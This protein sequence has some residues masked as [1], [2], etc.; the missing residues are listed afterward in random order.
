M[1]VP[2]SGPQGPPWPLGS[3]E[4]I[5]TPGALTSGFSCSETG[6]GPAEEKLAITSEVVTAA[7]VIAEGAF[8]GELTD[9]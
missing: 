6:V 8:P 3:E 1:L 9:P 5:P 4:V 7:T 2:W